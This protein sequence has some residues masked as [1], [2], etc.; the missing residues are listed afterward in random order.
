MDALRVLEFPTSSFDL[1]NQ[2]LGAT[3]AQN[4]GVDKASRR[5]PTS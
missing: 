4:M 3:L 1:V 5:I 2:R